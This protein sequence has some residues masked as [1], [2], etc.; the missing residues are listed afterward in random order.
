MQFRSSVRVYL[1]S[2]DLMIKVFVFGALVIVAA[3]A[4][5][6]VQEWVLLTVIGLVLFGASQLPSF[7]KGLKRGVREFRKANKDV[8]DAL[9][10]STRP[11]MIWPV[12][13]ALTHTNQTVECDP[14]P[15]PAADGSPILWFAQGFGIGRLKPAPGTW[16]TLLGLAWF[17][18]LVATGSVMAFF[19]GILVSIPVSAWACGKAELA[20]RRQDPP[21]VVLDEIIAVPLCFSA[22]VLN[23][24][25]ATDQMPEVS[26]FLSGNNW[27]GVIGIFAAF[28]L[29]DIWKPWPVRQSQSLPG[30]WGV[31]VDD[32][33]AAVYVNLVSLPFLL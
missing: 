25:H 12:A 29:F 14:P 23:H 16:G 8:N 6:S 26:Y 32:L 20:L 3:L 19:I 9:D 21:S 5:I 22:W 7:F 18:A 1:N 13:D 24:V 2:M 31:T 10:E 30:G 11:P 4:G 17:A 15:E 33:L 27:L 28:R